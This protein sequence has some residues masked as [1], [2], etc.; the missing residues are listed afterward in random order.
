MV[1]EDSE[2]SKFPCALGSVLWPVRALSFQSFP[3]CE[4]CVVMCEVKT[5]RF[6]VYMYVGPVLWYFQAL[7]QYWRD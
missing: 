5:L 2:S 6:K 7:S 3:R 4:L 1:C